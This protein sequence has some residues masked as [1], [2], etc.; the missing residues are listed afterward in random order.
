M[1]AHAVSVEGEA[2]LVKFRREVGGELLRIGCERLDAL[3]SMEG[4]RPLRSV[5]TFSARKNGAQK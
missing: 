3:G 5:V 1:V 4:W 2:A